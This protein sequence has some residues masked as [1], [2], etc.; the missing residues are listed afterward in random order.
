MEKNQSADGENSGRS[1]CVIW[2]IKAGYL[3]QA[4]NWGTEENWVKYVS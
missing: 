1:I 2:I 3:H 4:A